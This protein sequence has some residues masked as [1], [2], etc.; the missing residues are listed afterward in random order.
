M[1][2]IILLTATLLV[3]TSYAQL[4]DAGGDP[5]TDRAA[6]L[7]ERAK[8]QNGQSNDKKPS[9][10]FTQ[11]GIIAEWVKLDALVANRLL[12]EQLTENN[13]AALRESVFALIEKKTASLLGTSYVKTS[14]GNTSSSTSVDE[15]IYPTEWEQPGL[16]KTG[17]N[18]KENSA[19]L[20]AAPTA[21]EMR[22]VGPTIEVAATIGAVENP[23]NISVNID[24]SW[25]IYEG[26]DYIGKEGSTNVELRDIWMPK[27]FVIQTSASVTLRDGEQILLAAK[28]AK[29]EG[30]T[31]FLFLQANI[32][33]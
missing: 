25:T 13:A 21:F 3:S 17:E 27:F 20:A 33:R 9:F 14:S 10:D 29:E 2:P 16:P 7:L 32:L 24:A 28:N 31:V 23:V 12:R 6:V 18:K 22:P 5:F 4:G 1:K 15:A 8:L 19:I 30:Q 26:R 11:I